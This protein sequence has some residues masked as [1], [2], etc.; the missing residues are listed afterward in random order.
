MIDAVQFSITRIDSRTFRLV[1][2]TETEII[3]TYHLTQVEIHTTIEFELSKLQE[4]AR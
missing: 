3:R 2:Q 4:F 1:V